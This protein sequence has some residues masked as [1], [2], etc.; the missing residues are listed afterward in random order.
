MSASRV[1]AMLLMLCFICP[2]QVNAGERFQPGVEFNP[3]R[4]LMGQDVRAIS[5]GFSLFDGERFAE[6]AVMF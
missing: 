2:P 3:F 4:L 1:T 6:I 5:A